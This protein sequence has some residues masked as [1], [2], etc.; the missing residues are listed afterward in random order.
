[1]A[2]N[3]KIQWCDSTVNPTMGCDGCELWSK[4]NRTCYAG[5]L[6]TR[7]GGI[8][9]SY[10]PSFDQVTKFPGRMV[11]AARWSDLTGK[12]RPEKPWLDGMPRTIFV[13]DMSDSLSKSVPFDYLE[14]ELV[15]NVISEQG[16]RHQWL[17]LTKRPDRMA[18]FSAIL[19]EKG[20]P[21]PVNLWAGTSVTDSKT[22]SRIEKLLDVGD[23]NTLRFVS[24]EPQ[25]EHIELEKWLPGLDWVIHGG[26]SGLGAR[27]F[28]IEWA[29]EL[30]AQ[31]RKHKVPYFLKQLGAVVTNK[32]KL[33]SF[34]DAHASDWEH[35]P[36]KLRVR[37]MPP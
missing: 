2:Q 12:H 33:V 22:T 23:E 8:T 19:A 17:W 16:Q 31:C 4:H 10:A 24:V 18:K 1:M 32:G 5:I 34:E 27:A 26:E 28:E 30:I 11:Q 15:A 37:Q 21:W 7:F 25:V 29:S 13:S 6:H 20:T 9:K 35:W 3:T 14:D 36:R